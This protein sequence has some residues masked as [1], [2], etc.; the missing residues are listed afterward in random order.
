MKRS[1]HH[2]FLECLLVLDWIGSIC[3][4]ISVALGLEKCSRRTKS[5]VVAW[6]RTDRQVTEAVHNESDWAIDIS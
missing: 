1:M 2:I 3:G 4:K 5:V 6:G